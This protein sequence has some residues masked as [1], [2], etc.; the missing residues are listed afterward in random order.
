MTVPK[1]TPPELEVDGLYVIAVRGSTRQQV[2]DCSVSAYGNSYVKLFGSSQ[3][4]R[5]AL[6]R[7]IEVV[8]PNIYPTP[9]KP[10]S[11]W[12]A[13]EDARAAVAAAEGR[14]EE[15]EG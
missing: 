11:A 7:L 10:Q 15:K 9:D 6:K 8:E 5:A 1:H 4:M 12:A 2:A 14:T 3:K 13:L